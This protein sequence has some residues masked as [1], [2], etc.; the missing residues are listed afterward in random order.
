MKNADKTIRPRRY[1]VS[2]F[3]GVFLCA[4]Q[5]VGAQ[6]LTYTFNN[7]TLSGPE[8]V[9]VNGFQNVS[10][11]NSSD[12]QVDMPIVRL[13]DGATMQ[14]YQEAD[15]AV[16]DAF[17]Q[18]NGDARGPLKTLLGLVDAVGGVNLAAHTRGSA[19]VRL[20]PG[21]Y[22]VTAGIGGGP[23]DPYRPTYLGV[24]VT[25]GERAEAP[26]ADFRLQMMDFHFDFPQ[27][28]RSGEQLWE[29]SNTGSQP[30]FALIFT[31]LEGKT[32]ED[33]TAWMADMSGP[34]PLILKGAP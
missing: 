14:A 22:V 32:A 2:A 10:F 19:Y 24:T 8:T 11:I 16:N 25:E 26:K 33:V 20:E 27:T 4:A 23:G 34:P 3:L 29:V 9:A 1:S 5:L 31:L 30:H 18:R 13:R 6:E 17:S 21:T 15:R 12:E 28:M 7:N